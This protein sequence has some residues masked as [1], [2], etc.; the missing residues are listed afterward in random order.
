LVD[1]I[2]ANDL[3]VRDLYQS[4]GEVVGFGDMIVLNFFTL[5]GISHV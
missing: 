4:L 3:K 1:Y 2:K 5:I